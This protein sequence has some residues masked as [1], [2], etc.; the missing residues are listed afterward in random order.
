MKLNSGK[1]QPNGMCKIMFLVNS[2]H[3][4]PH[5][6]IIATYLTVAVYLRSPYESSSVD[7]RPILL[8][9]YC[10]RVTAMRVFC[11]FF[12]ELIESHAGMPAG[13]AS[14]NASLIGVNARRQ[15]RCDSGGNSSAEASKDDVISQLGC[16]TPP[17]RC[18][19]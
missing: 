12:S 3:R 18:Q 6:S 2:P 11:S 9:I 17:P 8:S 15:Q 14:E 4:C 19:H 7:L 5:S 13:L 16:G 10:S 1:V